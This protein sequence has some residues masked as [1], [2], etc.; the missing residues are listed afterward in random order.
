MRRRR[1][2]PRGGRSRRWRD[3]S[4][5]RR[6]RW[7]DRGWPRRGPRG[8]PGGG[9]RGRRRS[10][11]RRRRRGGPRA[12]PRRGRDGRGAG[13]PRGG[14]SGRCGG[15]AGLGLTPQVLHSG[16]EP[17]QGRGSPGGGGI[18]RRGGLAR[19]RSGRG[20]CGVKRGEKRSWKGGD[21][22]GGWSEAAACAV[23]VNIQKNARADAGRSRAL[24]DS[25]EKIP[26]PNPV[27]P[28]QN[29]LPFP[30]GPDSSALGFSGRSI[31]DKLVGPADGPPGDA[32]LLSGGAPVSH[33]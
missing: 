31:G 25:D 20:R 8:P 7:R 14:G 23:G 33:D 30:A 24:A 11:P 27:I 5:R 17:G 10:P 3:R 18:A 21:A 29:Y 4:R 28:Q 6:R 2:P 16:A 13:P 1:R 26:C 22:V 19:L 15:V 12:R 9:R 32:I